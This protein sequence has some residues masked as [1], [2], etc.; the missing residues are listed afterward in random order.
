MKRSLHHSREFHQP[1]FRGGASVTRAILL[2]TGLVVATLG[3]APAAQATMHPGSIAGTVTDDANMPLPGITVSVIRIGIYGDIE[4]VLGQDETDATGAFQV[5]DLE[6]YPNYKV[7]FTDPGAEYA[8]EFYDDNVAAGLATPVPVTAFDVTTGI[9][10]SLEPAASISGQLTTA[11]G[12]PVTSGQVWLTWL[13]PHTGVA[14]ME[15]HVTDQTGHYSIVGVKAATY[16]VAFWDPATDNAEWWD[17]KSWAN[18]SGPLSATPLAVTRGGSLT[19][20]DAV[21][22][23]TVTNVEVPAVTGKAQV[24]QSLTAS[25]G[26]WS[27]LGTTV[28]YRWV[29][30]AD[31]VAG[32]DPTGPV[33]WPTPADVGKTIRVYATGTRPGWLA[34]SASSNPTAAVAAAPVTSP[35]AAVTYLVRPRVK[36]T[37]QVGHVVRVS[38]GVWKPVTV[39]FEYQWY[40]GGK[41]ITHA[42]HRRLTLTDTYAGKRLSVRVK[43][44][45]AGYNRAIVWTKPTA[46]I[47]P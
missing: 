16:A 24:G 2:V 40:A 22:G 23:G 45:A 38:K 25:A 42:T 13:S 19:G 5:A 32:D 44:R 4:A 37:V 1:G 6:A 9:D 46:R 39:A 41:A 8:T 30:G 7:R 34:G 3:P 33:Y 28:S 14:R 26:T 21:L 47:T 31:T 43:A 11:T 29:V 18:M 35:P 20:I 10:A 15:T 27:P 12:A 17:D 36:G